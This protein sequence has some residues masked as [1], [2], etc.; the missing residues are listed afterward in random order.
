MPSPLPPNEDFWLRPWVQG[1]TT[2]IPNYDFT[3]INYHTHFAHTNHFVLFVTKICVFPLVLTFEMLLIKLQLSSGSLDWCQQPERRLFFFTMAFFRLFLN[4]S[5]LWCK[6]TIF[7]NAFKLSALNSCHLLHYW[8][9]VN[10]DST[11][12]LWMLETHHRM[13]WLWKLSI[14]GDVLLP[15]AATRIQ[16]AT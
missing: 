6:L 13:I 14:V 5:V 2:F 8:W 15:I 4:F 12:S 10:Y 7:N 16:S 11:C 1:G 3:D 9:F